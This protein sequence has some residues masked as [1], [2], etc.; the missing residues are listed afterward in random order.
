MEISCIQIFA[1]SCSTKYFKKSLKVTIK[2]YY[3]FSC[4]TLN[5]N[6]CLVY[7]FCKNT[8]EFVFIL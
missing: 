7:W 8:V 5:K 6:N 3:E 4:N 1:C 2:M